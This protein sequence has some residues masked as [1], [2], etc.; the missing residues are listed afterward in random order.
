MLGIGYWSCDGDC[1]LLFVRPKVSSLSA[2]TLLSH[3][4]SPHG[5]CCNLRASVQNGCNSQKWKLVSR[6]VRRCLRAFVLML[7]H[8]LN[9]AHC[10]FLVIQ[11]CHTLILLI[12]P[13]TCRN[14]STSF[15]VLPFLVFLLLVLIL[16]ALNVTAKLMWES[17][18]KCCS[19][20]KNKTNVYVVKCTDKSMIFKYFVCMAGSSVTLP[21]SVH[22]SFQFAMVPFVFKAIYSSI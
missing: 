16:C 22:N 2:Q 10:L 19:T 17:L 8:Q 9:L 14:T 5:A 15:A 11:H 4:Q 21:T 12:F 13:I 20:A 6:A 1:L 3:S 7:L 18:L